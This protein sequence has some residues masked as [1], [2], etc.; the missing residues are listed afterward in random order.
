MS[1]FCCQ[2]EAKSSAFRDVAVTFYTA[3]S[4]A[5][6]HRVNRLP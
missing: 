4:G 1:V 3:L 6:E 2:K 5:A